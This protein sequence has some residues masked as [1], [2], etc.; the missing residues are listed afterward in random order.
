[1]LIDILKQPRTTHVRIHL[2]YDIYKSDLLHDLDTE[3]QQQFGIFQLVPCWPCGTARGWLVG[4]GHWT[5]VVSI[6]DDQIIK[7]TI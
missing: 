3:R 7:A 6:S 2:D 1:M 4:G 5:L